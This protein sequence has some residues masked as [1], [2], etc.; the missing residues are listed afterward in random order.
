MIMLRASAVL[1]LLLM[2]PGVA[3]LEVLVTPPTA[4]LEPG[5]AGEPLDV[6]VLIPCDELVPRTL[7]Q[8]GATTIDFAFEAPE[9]IVLNGPTNMP[10][11]PDQCIESPSEDVTASMQLMAA[12]TFDAPGLE[13]IPFQVEATLVSQ[14]PGFEDI[15]ASGPASVMVGFHG[16][17]T[18]EVD[19]SIQLVEPGEQAEFVVTYTN[20]GNAATTLRFDIASEGADV[21][22]VD[23]MVVARGD[24]VAVS[25]F[26]TPDHSLGWN[27][28]QI[29]ITI[30]TTTFATDDESATGNVLTASLLLSS[31]GFA[32]VGDPPVVATPGPGLASIALAG[33]CAAWVARRP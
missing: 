31:R 13:N 3:A 29:P 26:A 22:P 33:L 10:L 32:T 20:H 19:R 11:L 24:E 12:A 9:G 6:E 16:E 28:E 5:L 27:N 21:P 2:A 7:G 1:G 23:D 15:T 18:L 8:G 17:I 14:T 4:M 30:T 25:V